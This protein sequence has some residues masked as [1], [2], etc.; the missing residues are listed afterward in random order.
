MIHSLQEYHAYEIKSFDRP[1]KPKFVSVSLEYFENI[2]IALFRCTTMETYDR[3]IKQQL[4]GCLYLRLAIF[5]F[6]FLRLFPFNLHI[7]F[8][9]KP[10][11]Y[12]KR[13][14]CRV[15]TFPLTRVPPHNNLHIYTDQ[16]NTETTNSR[17][18]SE[19]VPR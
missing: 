10:A 8:V 15:V 18:D 16:I 4:K 9:S 11:S 3:N 12:S 17:N 13:R 7:C 14:K 6:G 1:L 5:A 2:S 19:S